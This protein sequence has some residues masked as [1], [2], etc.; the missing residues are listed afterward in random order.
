[1]SLFVISAVQGTDLISLLLGPDSPVIYEQVY[2]VF[3][4]VRDCVHVV[5]LRTTNMITCWKLI[6]FDSMIS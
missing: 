1:M 6:D 5:D 3:R 2:I 4:S